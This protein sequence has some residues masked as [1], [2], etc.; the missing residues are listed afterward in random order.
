[1]RRAVRAVV[2]VMGAVSLV[3][4]VQAG[5]PHGIEEGRETRSATAGNEALPDLVP[6]LPGF[7][8]DGAD[9]ARDE[10][11]GLYTA[12]L[13]DQAVHECM[14]DA[15]F[16]WH[17]EAIYPPQDTAR[18]AAWVG[19]AREPSVDPVWAND[20]VQDALNPSQLDAYYI[21]LYGVDRKDFVTAEKD[22][23]ALSGCDAERS[24]VVGLWELRDKVELRS[25]EAR[26]QYRTTSVHQ[27]WTAQAA[28]CSAA[29]PGGAGI[30]GPESRDEVLAE[31]EDVEVVIAVEE[32]CRT[33]WDAD[34]AAMRV[35]VAQELATTPEAEQLREFAETME[36]QL[37]ADEEFV[38]WLRTVEYP[39]PASSLTQ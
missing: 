18:A 34:T 24:K 21:A 3:G 7:A 32:A 4:C 19:V 35:Y 39:Q 2:A 38:G 25:P 31:G 8:I 26:R 12:Y 1:M 10:A 11:L 13:R 27:Q 17:I 15:G 9:R 6:P 22:G 37:R 36:R 5:Q 30:T 20:L 28:A 33:L 16:E 29:V 23:L 14:S